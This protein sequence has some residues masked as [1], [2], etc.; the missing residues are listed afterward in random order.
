MLFPSAPTTVLEPSSYASTATQSAQRTVSESSGG[1][2]D[3]KQMP[4]SDTV[5]RWLLG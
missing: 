4:R 3:A 1:S 2:F 5:K